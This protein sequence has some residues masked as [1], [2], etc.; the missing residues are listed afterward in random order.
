[1]T[2]DD[3]IDKIMKE[4]NATTEAVKSLIN[5]KQRKKGE[6]SDVEIK[7]DLSEDEVKLHTILNVLGDIL[8]G[9]EKDFSNSSILLNVIEKKERK[10][11]SKGRQSRLEIVQV[12]RQ[13]DMFF[14]TNNE[15]IGK[16]SMMRKFFTSRRQNPPM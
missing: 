3:E 9:G 12:A 10:S 14:P 5:V 6:S 11:I 2:V 7:T 8:E 4:E 15:G 1:M 13:P 16:Q